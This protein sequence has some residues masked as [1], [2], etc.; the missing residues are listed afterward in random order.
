MI[1]YLV[2]FVGL[3]GSCLMAAYYLWFYKPDRALPMYGL[4]IGTLILSVIGATIRLRPTHLPILDEDTGDVAVR[5]W[6]ESDRLLFPHECVKVWWSVVGD[7]E[8]TFNGISVPAEDYI[9]EGTHCAQNGDNATLEVLA[10]DRSWHSYDLPIP[11][12]ISDS[13]TS[14]PYYLW[15]VFAILLGI[16]VYM[17]LAIQTLRRNWQ[18]GARSDIVSCIGCFLFALVF[19][20]PFGFDSAALYE[21]WVVHSYFDGRSASYLG[22]ELVSRFLGANTAHVSLPH[23]LGLLR[24]VSSGSF[25]DTCWQDDLAFRRI[26]SIK[27]VAVLQLSD[28]RIIHGLS[29]QFRSAVFAFITIELQY[30]LS[31]GSRILCIRLL[32]TSPTAGA[33]GRLAGADVQRRLE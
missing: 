29:G 18:S 9:G 21:E 6:A 1:F 3:V 22:P 16:L 8:L 28:C 24:R 32:S 20:L 10:N 15:S 14:A 2:G 30:A 27:D 4:L 31:S 26:A 7:L 23:Q 17:P 33:H 5:F 12:L 19:Y 25:S 11:S 13:L